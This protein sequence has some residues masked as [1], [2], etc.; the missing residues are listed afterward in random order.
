MTSKIIALDSLS[1]IT[2]ELKRNG[3]K[4]AHC[5]GCFDLMHLG[6]IKHFE[7]AKQAADVLIVTITPD[8]FVNKGPGRPVFNEIHRMEAIA[9]LQCV[10]YVALN[11]WETAVET[12]K[13]VKP[14]LYVKGQDYKNASDDITGNIGFEEEAVKTVG[15]KFYI[16]EEVQFSSS[17]LINAHFSPLSDTVQSFLADFKSKHSADTIIAEIEKLKDAKVLVIGDT[18]IDEYH[19]CKPLGKSSKSPTISSVYLRGE[20]Y[21]GGVLAIANHLS[22]FAGKV[23]MITCLGEE[24]TQLELIQEKLSPAIESKF[25]YRKNAPTPT[26]RRYLDKYLNIKLFEVTFMNDSYIEQELETSMIAYLEKVLPQYDMVMIADFGHGLISPNIIKFL[27]KSGKYLA[28][29][30]QTNSNNYGFNYIT[31]YSRADYISID[32][33]ELRLPFG[34]NYGKV[35]PLIE[36]LKAITHAGLIQITLG[37]EGSVLYYDNKFAKAPAFASA[38]KDSVGAG[39]AVLSVTALCAL[40]NVSPEVIAFVGNSV[41]SLAVEI[42]GNEHPV[43]KKDLTK[44]I[45][46]LL[47]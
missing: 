35:E 39:D 34:D 13:I 17:K 45:K 47:K 4:I 43:Y 3:K 10:D 15:G 38:V 41:G 6:H 37:Q 8:R 40:K 16:T 25:F 32:E 7:A 20:S 22:Q 14:D 33:K 18:I 26:K 28:V 21:A 5:H 46:H 12:I 1:A 42:I 31:K 29:N 19:Y 2:T 24:N 11:K 27:E 9:A 44:F 30:A 36:K 23:E